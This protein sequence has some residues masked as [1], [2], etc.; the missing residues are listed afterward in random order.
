MKNNNRLMPLVAMAVAAVAASCAGDELTSDTGKQQPSDGT[1]TKPVALTASVADPAGTRAGMTK[2]GTNA[3]FYWHE[4]DAISV[5]TRNGDTYSSAK[6]T[7]ADADG[8]LTATFSGTIGKDYE[9]GGYAVYPYSDSHDLTSATSL[10]CNLP[11]AYTAYK[12]ESAIFSKTTEGTTTYPTN[13]VNMLMLGVTGEG[14]VEF[15]HLGGLAVIRI[16]Q[17]PS[18]EGTLTV[19]ADQQLSGSF[20]VADVS[21]ADAAIVTQASSADNTVTFTFTGAIKGGV[22]VFYLPMATGSYTNLKIAVSDGTTTQTIPYGD[23]SVARKDVT[24]ISLTTHNGYLRNFRA[25]GNDKYMVNGHVFVDLGLSVLWAETNIGATTAAD[26]G[27]YYA[28]GETEPKETYT[29]GTYKYGTSRTDI[30]KYTESYLTLESMD[31]AASVNWGY[32]CR[33]PTFTEIKG[34]ID[35]CTWTW[36]SKQT[37]SGGTINGWEVSN[38]TNSNSIF[39]PASGERVDKIY[40]Y[41]SQGYYWASTRWPNYVSGAYMILFNSSNS[42]DSGADRCYG[43]SVRAVAEP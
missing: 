10:M 17:M 31:D 30:T 1:Q 22:G 13:S 16:D 32:G 21:A 40:S 3:T 8:T 33:M 43:N 37:S 11:A 9:V 29:W 34:L 20:A 25:L 5:Q 28:W 41:G 35:N 15:R 36:T 24:A 14:T 18:A 39:L 27:N 38:Q 26:D 4:G 19:T 7:T 12:V 42:N 23:L 2:D 6:L